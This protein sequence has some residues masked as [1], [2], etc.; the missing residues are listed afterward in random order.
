MTHSLSSD[1]TRRAF[2][3]AGAATTT[4]LT[5][6]AYERVLGANERIGVGFIGYGLIGKRH[7]L[8]FQEQKD[9]DLVG[10]AEVHRG[11]REEAVALIGA[12]CKGYADFRKLLGSKDVQA[13]VI[14]TPDHWHAL[15][16]MLA[17]AAGKDVFVE[18]PLTLF[19][20]E[21]RWMIDVARKHKRVVQVGTQQRSG[22]HYQRAR[23]L[24]RDGQLGK[25][26]SV[27]MGTFRNIMPG[28]GTPMDSDP[29]KD[30]DWESWLGPAPLRKYNPNRAIYHFRWFWDYSGGQ[31]TNLAAHSLDIVHW[32][33]GVTGPTSVTS[34]GGR[35]SLQDN[36][37]TPDTQDSII[38]YPGFTAIWSH[39]E[40]CTGQSQGGLEFCGPKGSLSI[41]RAGFKLV[42]DRK[43]PPEN[44]VPQFTGAHPVGGPKRVEAG[45]AQWWTKSVE[46]N[47]GNSR[48]QFT[49]HVRN[50]LDCIV[51]RKEPISD[52]ESSNRVATVCHLAN[53]SLRIGRG[54]RWDAKSEE[55]ID[56]AEASK[57]LVRA[58]RA[59][60]DKELTALL[61]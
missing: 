52:L 3:Q 23:E 50:F 17:C 45:P 9:A 36:G 14:S 49:Q 22:T 18:K 4:V 12:G 27:R 5:A 33:L 55:V 46:D 56:D 59:P 7:V 24:V 29:P 19:V 42:G 28:F 60:W 37:E 34:V 58:Y 6:S 21:G 25:V 1:L 39:R 8:D 10:V 15:Q 13:V 48:S 35:F 30:L 38:E 2:V 40:A 41:S 53:I 43:I 32:F 57:M 20:R 31:M 16:T 54:L 61:Q 26:S 11:R 47:T 44:A 51:S